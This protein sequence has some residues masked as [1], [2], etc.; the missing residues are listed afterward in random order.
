MT[1]YEY[2]HPEPDNSFETPHAPGSS[3]LDSD[4]YSTN[5]WDVISMSPNSYSAASKDSAPGT[6]P[7]TMTDWYPM[8]NSGSGS[9]SDTTSYQSPPNTNNDAT[10]SK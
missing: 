10:T 9:S 1:E 7:Y 5:S 4:A 8:G 3:H 2:S 6:L